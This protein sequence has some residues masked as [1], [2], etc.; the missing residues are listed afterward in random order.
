[1][2]AQPQKP[3][4]KNVHLT[5]PPEISGNPLVCNLTRLFDLT[6]NILKAQITP[7]KEGYITLELMGDEANCTKAM[8]YLREHDVVV[9]PVAQRISRDEEGCMHC[10]MCTAICPTSALRMNLENRTVTFELD[11]CTA[12]GLCTRVCPVAAMHVELENG[13]Y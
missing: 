3:Y 7:R 4:R 9:T 13:H 11:R 8:E 10:G 6:F 5:F 12:C 1:M 2:S